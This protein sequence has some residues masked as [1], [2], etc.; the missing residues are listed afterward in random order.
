[1]IRT[2]VVWKRQDADLAALKEAVRDAVAA[3]L[4]SIAD[5]CAADARS[6]APV[7]TGALRDSIEPE[8]E[9][10]L[11][12]SVVAGVP[13]AAHV[14]YGTRHMAA[15][16]FLTPAVGRAESSAPSRLAAAARRAMEAAGRRNG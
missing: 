9:S 14:E 1:M 6:R 4:E 7:R 16:P 8:Q 12:W 13:Y 3:E 15:R 11:H 5:D 2:Q 10:E